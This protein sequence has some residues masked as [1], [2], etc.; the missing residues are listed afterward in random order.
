MNRKV[1]GKKAEK[2]REKRISGEMLLY[3]GQDLH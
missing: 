2:K 1:G 3:G